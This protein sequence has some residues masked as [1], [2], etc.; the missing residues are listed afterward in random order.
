MIWYKLTF[1]IKLLQ[2]N[3]TVK[4]QVLAS[5]YKAEDAK[6]SCVELINFGNFCQ[7]FKLI[8]VSSTLS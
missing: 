1:P 5:R 8:I 4:I 2:F 7:K 3:Y 6:I